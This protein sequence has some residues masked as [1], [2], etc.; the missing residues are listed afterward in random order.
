MMKHQA[1]LIGSILGVIVLSALLLFGLNFNIQTFQFASS[2]KLRLQ[3]SLTGVVQKIDIQVADYSIE[4]KLGPFAYEVYASDSK[5]LPTV[6]VSNRTLKITQT[7]E[8]SIFDRFNFTF[9]PSKIVVY[10]PE[11]SYNALSMTNTS[12]SIDVRD[13]AFMNLEL[14]SV[15]G[16]ITALHVDP[17]EAKLHSI[18]GTILFDQSANDSL[19][20]SLEASNVSGTINLSANA[21]QVVMNNISGKS[22][23]NAIADHTKSITSTN[24]SGK[25][26]IYFP[27]TQG[28]TLHSE[29]VSGKV[30]SDFDIVNDTY[31]DGTCKI[32]LTSTSGGL[33]VIE[34]EG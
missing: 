11:A 24:V 3:E 20:Q 31:G 26:E 9:T 5:Q 16:S 33:Y 34:K 4:I 15:S 25:T 29:S 18:S 14:T 22:V 1:R 30:S 19:I 28:F 6:E 17:L 2:E 21:Q 32:S 7:E 10:L 12:G 27:P 13:V 23:F 8:T